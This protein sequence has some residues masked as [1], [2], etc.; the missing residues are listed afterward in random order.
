MNR[1]PIHQMMS[2]GRAC[3]LV[4][5]LL[6]AKSPAEAVNPSIACPQHAARSGLHT[7]KQGGIQRSYRVLLPEAVGTPAPLIL[8]FHG[9]GG[10]ENQFLQDGQLA[11]LSR[12]RGFVI[13]APRGLGSDGE[14]QSLNSWSFSGSTT[15]LDADGINAEVAGDTAAICDDAITPDYSFPSCAQVKSNSCSWTHCQADDVDFTLQLIGELSAGYCIDLDNIFVV[16]GSNGGM[17]AW[18]LAQN[19]KSAP[20]FRAIAPIIGLPH[21]GYL[22]PP[23]A[24]RPIPALLITGLLDEA[25]PP[26]EWEDSTFTTTSNDNDRYYY[27]GASAIMRTW[28]QAHGCSV[29]EPAAPLKAAN[30]DADCRTYCP[31]ESS[32]P[33]VLDCRAQMGHDYGLS[34]SWELI[35]DFFQAHAEGGSE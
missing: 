30:P 22:K 33:A 13:A 5:T 10:D 26:G 35:L 23:G 11:A 3:V 12:E 8:V 32:F 18:E 7:L 20:M 9:W 4:I 29:D 16:G 27:T 21:R 14:D 34:W 6:A 31:Q 24:A 28:S 19:P 25:V 17:F 2:S 15:G 1:Q